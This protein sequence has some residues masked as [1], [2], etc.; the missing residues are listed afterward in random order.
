MLS[1]GK[2][3]RNCDPEGGAGWIG[4]VGEGPTEEEIMRINLKG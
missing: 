4:L 3:R 1:R 2:K